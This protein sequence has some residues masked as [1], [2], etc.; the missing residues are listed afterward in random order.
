VLEDTDIT[1]INISMLY[2]A[3]SAARKRAK[4]KAIYTYGD[5][6]FLTI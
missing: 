5:W 2:V 4:R 3:V 1:N 6:F